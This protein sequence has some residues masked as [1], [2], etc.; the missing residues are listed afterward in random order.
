MRYILVA[1][2]FLIVLSFKAT[3][4]TK[5]A[6]FRDD[7]SLYP[8]S[9]SW[10]YY[11]NKP[12]SWQAGSNP[13]DLF[14]GEIGTVSSYAP[15]ISTGNMLSADGDENGGNSSPD[16]FIRLNQ[17]GGHPGAPGTNTNL[18]R[19]AICA[20]TV[21]TPGNYYI[22]SSSVSLSNSKSNGVLVYI[23]VNSGTSLLKK[24]ISASG[25]QA[26]DVAIG[27]LV[28]GDVIYVCIGANG[29]SAYDSFDMNFDI[30]IVDEPETNDYY[31][32]D[33]GAAGNGSANDM[34]AI[35][36][37]VNDFANDPFPARLHFENKTYR[38]TGSG[39]L[40]DLNGAKN[41]TILGNGAEL[42]V[43]PS[44]LGLQING[45]ENVVVKDL[46]FD[47]D[48]LSWTQGTI[49]SI[50]AANKKF[51]LEIDEG[52]PIPTNNYG[53]S[54]RAH[55]WGMIWEP[56]GYTIK[57]ELVWVASSR[58][59][60][61]NTVELSLQDQSPNALNDMNANDR[62][63]VDVYG[64][65]GSFNLISES[66][67]I[68]CENL[69]FYATRSLVFA[70]LDNVGLIHMNGV[71]MRRKQGTNRLLSCYRDGFH[72]KRNTQGP[73]IENCYID[74]LC[75]DAINLSG[76]YYYVT[77]K[78]SSTQFLLDNASGFSEG[79]TLLF[80]DM[81]KGI[82]LGKT[83]VASKSGNE[84]NTTSAISGVVAGGPKA[85]TTTFVMNLSKSNSGFIIR[86]NT[87]GGQR[88]YAM[89]IRSQ[90][91]LI[92]NNTGE[93]LGGGII[94]T[95]EINSFFEGPF[96]RNITIQNNSFS[97][98]RGWP[99]WLKSSTYAAVPEQLVQDIRLIDNT[100]G[101]SKG[102]MAAA[103][104]QHVD[105]VDFSGN[106]F[107]DDASSGGIA[108]TNSRNINV[109]CNNSYNGTNIL[110]LG[111]GI[112]FGDNMSA[113]DI[114][115]TCDTIATSI[116][117]S[118]MENSFQVYPNPVKDKLHIRTAI[119]SYQLEIIDV[120]GKRIK[121]KNN[122]P[123]NIELS[124]LSTG[125]YWVIVTTADEKFQRKIIKY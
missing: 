95:N 58:N 72:C 11:W 1:I 47:S 46:K 55:P 96:P 40:F 101:P 22:L 62:F 67:N 99:L 28:A 104:F 25:E 60:T 19:Y 82:E 123:D 113:S 122:T 70:L 2:F 105:N 114:T 10:K 88:R 6:G 93:K 23:H 35:R 85:S 108:I 109:E 118:I 83:Y 125:V 33:Y 91:G 24:V 115:F 79:D 120:Y 87:F 12:N 27:N 73:I 16:A 76:G 56:E 36:D 68:S 38:S 4:Q 52:Y 61:G 8:S 13:G 49:K 41:K 66:K 29:Q 74:G 42:I 17:N 15:L 112:V 81:K 94:L 102:G 78:S 119:K 84:I 54:G 39:I 32:S 100:F 86:N 59:L 63:T 121:T 90:N 77:G 92:E 89:L 14:T 103:T 18:D 110:S 106:N 30:S 117:Q 34:D 53:N 7:F 71:E 31:V 37:A 50:D 51:T 111:D 64:V 9:S 124:G 65:G 107:F 75:D 97:D 98:I 80:V 26:F 44:I 69:T 20:Y 5:V 43:E 21:N 3:A 57:N 45:S 48:P 116:K